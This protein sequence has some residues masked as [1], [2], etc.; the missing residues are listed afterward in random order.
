MLSRFKNVL[1]AQHL[2]T[3]GDCPTGL[4]PVFAI[5]AF[6][7]ASLIPNFCLAEE[8]LPR[9]LL[10]GDFVYNEP[11]RQLQKEL[12]GKAEVHYPRLDPGIVLSSSSVL[13]HFDTIVGE[14][15]WDLIHF[16]VGLGDLIH[17]APWMKSFRVFPKHAGGIPNTSPEQYEKN[18]RELAKRLKFTRAKLVWGSTTPIRHSSTNVFEL[19]SEI[20]YNTIAAKVMKEN[21]IPI[22]DMYTFAKGVMNMDKP[23]SHGADPFHFDK[24]PIHSPILKVIQQELGSAEKAK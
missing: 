10:L 21:E 17:R 13:E 6:L 3:L 15:N 9:V 22:N 1:K 11:S 20:E 16:N 7:L 19:K 5:F 12:K 23:A 14:G 2:S 24:K 18:L 4:Q 8:P